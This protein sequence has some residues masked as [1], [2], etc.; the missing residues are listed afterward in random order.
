MPAV[1]K[2]DYDVVTCQIITHC[3]AARNA[4][5]YKRINYDAL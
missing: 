2:S 1:G 4:G 5:V 3:C